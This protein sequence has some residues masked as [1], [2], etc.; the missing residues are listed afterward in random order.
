MKKLLLLFLSILLVV[1]ACPAVYAAQA[2]AP[3]VQ[4]QGAILVDLASGQVLYA[5][6]EHTKFYPAS[7]TKVMTSLLLLE[8]MQQQKIS[9][10]AEVVI[11]AEVENTPPESSVL[12]I[13]P[14]DKMTMRNLFTGFLLRSGNDAAIAIAVMVSGSEQAFVQKMNERAAQLGMTDTHF[15]N[16]HGM[17]DKEHYTTAADMVKVTEAAL[18]FPDFRQVTGTYETTFTYTRDGVTQKRTIDNS[19]SLLDNDPRNKYYYPYATGTKTGYLNDCTCSLVACA[20]KDGRELLAVFLK[21]DVANRYV[22]P[23]TLFEYGFNS[24]K[25]IDLAPL[26]TK[27]TFAIKVPNADVFD[28]ENGKLPLKPEIQTT[29]YYTAPNADI[30]N[31]QS[32]KGVAVTYD[33]VTAPVTAGSKINIHFSYNGS[34]IYKCSAAALRDVTAKP[35]SIEKM[36]EN[37]HFTGSL[38]TTQPDTPAAPAFPVSRFIK[39]LLFFAAVFAA[40]GYG[41]LKAVRTIKNHNKKR[42]KKALQFKPNSQINQ[43]YNKRKETIP[44]R[45]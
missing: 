11:P 27:G 18:A 3:P 41:L 16:P 28:P 39:Y 30:D 1:S 33:P 40:A 5:K 20:N 13:K 14:E 31:I 25:T 29:A 4:A 36:K 19:N 12:G 7:I 22:D 32:M 10:D 21:D 17:E 44:T 34:E 8:Y 15:V 9:M 43:A 42:R 45:R 2:P 6:N 35:D 37:L 23:V 26:L 38:S 24:F